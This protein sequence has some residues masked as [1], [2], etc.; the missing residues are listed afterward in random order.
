MFQDIAGNYTRAVYILPRKQYIALT[1]DERKFFL[2][3]KEYYWLGGSSILTLLIMTTVIYLTHGIIR[4]KCKTCNNKN[5]N[6]KE[7][8]EEIELQPLSVDNHTNTQEI[9]PLPRVLTIPTRNVRI[10]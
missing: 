1:E 10:A 2:A 3:D 5:I 9:H 8:Q 6:I 4:K 7:N